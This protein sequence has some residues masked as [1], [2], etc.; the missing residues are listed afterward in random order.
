MSMIPEDK[1]VNMSNKYDWIVSQTKTLEAET[2]E[3]ALDAAYEQMYVHTPA[4]FTYFNVQTGESGE[5][6]YDL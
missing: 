2:L 1:E 5:I 4:K 3:E 6:E